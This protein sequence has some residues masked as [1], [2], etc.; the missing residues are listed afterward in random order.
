MD[1]LHLQEKHIYKHLQPIFHSHGYKNIPGRQQ[2]RKES[3]QGFKNVHFTVCGNAEE[4]LIKIHLGI[5]INKVED[6]LEQFLQEPG[7]NSGDK[8]TVA[9]SVSRFFQQSHRPALLTD[10]RK[11]RDNY[12]EITSFM[13][14]KG[15]RFLESMSRLKRIDGLLNRKPELPSPFMPNQMHRCFKGIAMA[16]I[17]HRT[18]F[19][20]LVTIY[21]SYLY[22]HW[23]STEVMDNFKRLVN[24]LRYF[25]FN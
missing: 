12:Q 20:K 14:Q 23:A 21:S 24:Y 25:S 4:P 8:L 10:E 11:F 18:D 1:L 13:K 15:F 7:K 19:D 16:S 3:P 6:L 5:R 22:S 9:A 2:F 17:L